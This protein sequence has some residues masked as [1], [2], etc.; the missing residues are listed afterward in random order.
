M[1]QDEPRLHIR[2]SIGISLGI[3]TMTAFV[4]LIIKIFEVLKNEFR[5]F[6]AIK[7]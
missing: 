4:Y 1:D 3:G 7:I 2:P 6:N 5:G